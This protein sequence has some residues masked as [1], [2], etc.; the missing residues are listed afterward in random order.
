MS[1]LSLQ[2][3]DDLGQV[4]EQVRCIA[5]EL[6]NALAPVMGFAELLV[7]TGEDEMDPTRVRHYAGLILSGALDLQRAVES[8]QALYRG[9]I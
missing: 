6:N 9:R 2:D 4:L 8:L 5:H 3:S 7:D 1:A